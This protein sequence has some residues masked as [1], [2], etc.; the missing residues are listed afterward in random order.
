MRTRRCYLRNLTNILT[1]GSVIFVSLLSAIVDKAIHLD[2]ARWLSYIIYNKAFIM[3]FPHLRYSTFLFQLPS[4]LVSIFFPTKIDIIRETFLFSYAL[5]PVVF[6][7][8]IF[9][10]LKILKKGEYFVCFGLAHFAFIYPA[11]F[12]PVNTVVEGAMAFFILA[13]TE[14]FD[15]HNLRKN[16]IR[17][18]SSIFMLYSYESSIGFFIVLL[19][20]CILMSRKKTKGAC[21]LFLLVFYI[22]KAD[23]KFK[24]HGYGSQI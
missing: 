3:D 19:L 24:R 9:F 17:I 23:F 16:I 8:I 20:I 18:I 13:I 11:T 4:V 21:C 15:N 22:R 12:F 6:I 1:L 5:M 10:Y 14:S 2:G 7:L